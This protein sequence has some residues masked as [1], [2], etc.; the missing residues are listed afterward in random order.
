VPQPVGFAGRPERKVSHQLRYLPIYGGKVHFRDMVVL[1]AKRV[2]AWMNHLTEQEAND[3]KI[4]EVLFGRWCSFFPDVPRPDRS[5]ESFL[6]G[7]VIVK[8]YIDKLIVQR[9]KKKKLK[10][11]EAFIQEQIQDAQPLRSKGQKSLSVVQQ[12]EITDAAGGRNAAGLISGSTTVADQ[13]GGHVAPGAEASEFQAPQDPTAIAVPG[14]AR[15]PVASDTLAL[16]RG[17]DSTMFAASPLPWPPR[18]ISGEKQIG[19]ELW[20]AQADRSTPAHE[21]GLVGSGFDLLG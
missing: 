18:Q 11:A 4:D 5:I 10:L 21:I 13:V 8:D 14:S 1:S 7:H 19:D 20:E 3:V 2:Y 15:P 12:V 9:K 17:P 6:V 16:V